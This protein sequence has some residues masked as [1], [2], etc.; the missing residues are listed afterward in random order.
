VDAQALVTS[1]RTQAV[2]G[3]SYLKK[4][5]QLCMVAEVLYAQLAP[6]EAQALPLGERG[7]VNH[8]PTHEQAAPSCSSPQMASFYKLIMD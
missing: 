5:I 8:L 4:I 2:L 7:S 1:L 3:P 6:P